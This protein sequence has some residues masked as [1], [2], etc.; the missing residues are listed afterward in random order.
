MR[1]IRVGIV[2]GVAA[3]GIGAFGGYLV[4]NAAQADEIAV[5]TAL[6]ADRGASPPDPLP[7]HDT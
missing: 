4:A 6:L 3:L 7:D 1:P 2:T 5:M